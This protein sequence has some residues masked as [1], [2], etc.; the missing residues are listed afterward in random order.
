MPEARLPANTALRD[1]PPGG[2]LWLRKLVRHGLHQ[3]EKILGR[4]NGPKPALSME[5]EERE[6]GPG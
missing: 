4:G 5:L 1:A 6:M 3:R 2:V